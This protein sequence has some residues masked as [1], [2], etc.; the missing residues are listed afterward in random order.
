MFDD[1]GGSLFRYL[2]ILIGL[3]VAASDVSAGP[4]GPDY[5]ELWRGSDG[6]KVVARAEPGLHI[7]A[8]SKTFR[9]VRDPSVQATLVVA[10]SNSQPWYLMI[11][12]LPLRETA[13]QATIGVDAVVLGTKAHGRRSSLLRF[14]MN[15][16]MIEQITEGVKLWVSG[17]T[18]R[19][20]LEFNLAG[21][22]EAVGMLAKCH[23]RFLD[24]PVS[25]RGD[26]DRESAEAAPKP[27]LSTGTAF[28]VS[29]DGDFVT[30]AHVVESCS[31]VSIGQPGRS[32][33]RQATIRKVDRQ[34]DLALLRVA[35]GLGNN[36]VVLP[37]RTDVQLGEPVAA[38]GFPHWGTLASSGNFARG[39]VTA[40]D[41]LGD[42]PSHLQ[43]SVPVQPG[44][45][46]GPLLDESGN[47]V[48]VVVGKLNALKIAG[49]T[50]DIP[51]NV[52]FAI[53]ASYARAFLNA[54]GIEI[55]GHES[56]PLPASKL[57]DKARAATALVVCRTDQN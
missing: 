6:W 11:G 43:M 24:G 33:L 50:G 28:L 5:T 44:N 18:E 34:N 12:D 36:I 23:R 15:E 53:K 51:Q 27:S 42:Q 8:M 38:F 13:S 7:C 32:E 40:V 54:N 1:P 25:A 21:S 10:S 41:G 47:V 17:V 9:N 3:V 52:N 37:W 20:R 4:P 35:G 45:S 39:D 30:N 57:A 22:R 31:S 55:V 29:T 46:G 49:A 14:D 56:T 2:M 26:T 19:H 16:P 48:G